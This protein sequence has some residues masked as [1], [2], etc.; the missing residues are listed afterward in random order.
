MSYYQKTRGQFRA[1]NPGLSAEQ[2]RLQ[3]RGEW[4]ALGESGREPYLAY[5]QGVR[6]EGYASY[7]GQVR[8]SLMQENADITEDQLEEA[9]RAK[10]QLLDPVSQLLL[11]D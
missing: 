7:K 9:V 4:D 10:W 6:A 3:M 1:A 2:T 8:Q 11:F 5:V